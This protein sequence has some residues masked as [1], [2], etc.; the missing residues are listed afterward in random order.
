M[1]LLRLVFVWLNVFLTPGLAL[2]ADQ[3]PR[4]ILILDQSDISGPLS[5]QIFSGLVAALN[6]TPGAPVTVYFESLDLNRFIGQDYEQSLQ[7]RRAILQKADAGTRFAV[8]VFESAG[9]ILPTL[10]LSFA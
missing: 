10:F 2:A 7:Q 3:G 9:R 5:H 6:S 8:T 4:S 1:F